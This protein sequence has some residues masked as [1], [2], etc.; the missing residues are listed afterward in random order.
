MA[1]FMMTDLMPFVG[2]VSGAVVI[3]PLW[4]IFKRAGLTPGFSFLVF[5][6]FIGYLIVGLA[7]A[8]N[9][10]PATEGKEQRA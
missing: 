5:V 3:Y 7:L 8:L 6:P 4:R 1:R 2:L 9:R 10:W